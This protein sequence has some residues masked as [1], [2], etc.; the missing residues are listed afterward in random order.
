MLK[1]LKAGGFHAFLAL[2]HLKKLIASSE[3]ELLLWARRQGWGWHYIGA[4]LSKS[5]QAVQQRWKRLT[6]D[7]DY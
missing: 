6:R 3:V 7:W 4:L 1:R 5:P 2:E